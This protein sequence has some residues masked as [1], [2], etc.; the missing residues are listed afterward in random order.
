GYIWSARWGGYCLLR[1]DP[2]GKLERKIQIPAQ[3]PTSCIFGGPNLDELYITSA[4]TALGDDK[5][6]EQ[7]QAGDLFRLKTDVV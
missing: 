6:H 3:F 5:K 4:W 1:Y 7:P 2:E